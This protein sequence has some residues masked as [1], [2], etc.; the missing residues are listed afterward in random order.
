[1]HM[2]QKSYVVEYFIINDAVYTL[3]VKFQLVQLKML[4]YIEDFH[5]G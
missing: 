1:M 3:H 5:K 2:S 4:E